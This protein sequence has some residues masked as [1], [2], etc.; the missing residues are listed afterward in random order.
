MDDATALQC[1]KVAAEALSYLNQQKIPH[2]P[3]TPDDVYL[4]RDG[5]ARLN[6]LATLREGRNPPTQQDIRALSR[7]VSDCLPDRMAE[8]PGL[9]RAA[10]AACCWTAA[11][12]FL[13]WGALLQAVKA[14]EPKVVPE[15]AF[16]L[17]ARDAAALAAVN[18]AKRRQKRAVV[19]IDGRHVCFDLAGGSGGLRPVLSEQ[20]PPGRS[21]R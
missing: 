19:L 17:S 3:L 10:R 5:R 21:T 14:L 11:A 12:G 9:A 15:D 7:M 6:N 16:K 2:P 1:I 13:S 20:P 4:G 18:E 8:D